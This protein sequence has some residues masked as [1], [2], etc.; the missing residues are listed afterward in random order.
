MLAV[1]TAAGDTLPC[2]FVQANDTEASPSLAEAI[3]AACSQLAV[4][5]PAS[6]GARPAAPLYQAVVATAQ[7]P[8]L[9]I[10]ETPSLKAR[11]LA[12]WRAGRWAL[13]AAQLR[14]A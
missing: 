8:E 7:H 4:K 5:P 9:A 13:L 11:G 10:P 2:L 6:Y 12:A 1:A 3:G 14:G